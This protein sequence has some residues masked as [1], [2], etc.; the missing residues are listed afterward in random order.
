M[1]AIQMDN[2]TAIG[3]AEGFIESDSTEQILSAWA[4]IAERG[5]HRGLQGFFGRNVQTLVEQGL[6][7]WGGNIH[8][9]NLD[10][11]DED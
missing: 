7:D 5:L 10:L 11:N 9:Q 1:K 4:N 8:P 6:I 2:F 3:I